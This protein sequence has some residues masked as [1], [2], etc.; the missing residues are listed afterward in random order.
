MTGY[1]ERMFWFFAG[2]LSMLGIIFL[3]GAYVPLP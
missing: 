2:A 3:I 1:A